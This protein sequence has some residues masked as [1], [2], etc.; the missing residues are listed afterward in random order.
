MKQEMKYYI[1]RYLESCA[2]G[3]NDGYQKADSHENL[4]AIYCK[5]HPSADEDLVRRNTR[6]LTDYLDEE[7]DFPL[8]RAPRYS[9]LWHKFY[10]KFAQY[11]DEVTP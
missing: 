1:V 3:I 10:T 8:D 4:V 6:K 11:A 2:C 9:V 5:H 7:I